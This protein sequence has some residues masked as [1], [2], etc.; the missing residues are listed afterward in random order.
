M[1]PPASSSRE[2]R[3]PACGGPACR[4]TISQTK[5]GSE[6]GET[7]TASSTPWAE[8]GSQRP[9]KGSEG[10]TE[11]QRQQHPEM[12]I[13]DEP[14]GKKLI[15]RTHRHVLRHLG[16]LGSVTASLAD[17]FHLSD[18]ASLTK[19][20]Q[21]GVFP[22]RGVVRLSIPGVPRHWLRAEGAVM[23]RTE[24]PGCLRRRRSRNLHCKDLSMC[25]RADLNLENGRPWGTASLIQG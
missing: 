5:Q 16:V 10:E 19:E 24:L 7:S 13:K 23:E 9:R 4:N 2:P 25:S 21:D 15:T 20:E 3:S 6:E 22:G 17:S 18:Q 8:A 1:S 12:H 14:H 11:Q